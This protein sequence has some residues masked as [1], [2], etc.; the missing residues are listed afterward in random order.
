[1]FKIL[2]NLGENLR[3]FMLRNKPLF[4]FT[5]ETAVNRNSIKQKPTLQSGVYLRDRSGE[6]SRVT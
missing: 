5:E 6:N 2:I 4:K 3:D 1:M